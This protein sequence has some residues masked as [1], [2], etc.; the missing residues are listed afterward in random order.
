MTGLT[1]LVTGV[2]R[3]IGSA[4]AGY[5]AAHPS[6]DRVIGVDAAM[7]E[8]AARLRMGEAE[9]VRADIR[10]PL[11]SKVFEAAGVDTVV[12]ASASSTPSGSAA[13]TM[14]KEMNVLGTMQLLAACQRSMTLKNLIVRSTAAVYGGSSR[15]PA[16]ATEETMARAVPSTGLA[17]DAIDI[18]GYVRG[19]ARRR[20]DVR[21]A[22]PR[23]SEII[24][25]TVR[26]P[27]T[28][29][30]S[31][32][33]FVPISA[34][35]DARMQLVHEL[36]AVALIEHLVLGDF[37]GIVN[38]AG[39]GAMTVAQAIHRAGR[40]PLPIP[41]PALESVGRLLQAM[42]VGGFGG[43]SAAQIRL[44]SAGRVLDTSRLREQV[45]F[46]PRFSTTEAFDDFVGRLVPA[47]HPRA[48][49]AAELK[50]ASMIGVPAEPMGIRRARTAG[51]IADLAAGRLGAGTPDLPLGDVLVPGPGDVTDSTRPRLF[52]IDGDARR[53]LAVRSSRP[54]GRKK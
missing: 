2:T 11:I 49:R 42:G 41:S 48:V 52:S 16:V 45:G 22:V 5:L 8:P 25:P 13:R 34:G 9:F 44:L 29:Y 15:D 37:A 23:F 12:H 43:F 7:P 47:L 54:G 39:D 30:F 14:A 26:T 3:F 24:G 50:V 46:T 53:S 40:V 28:K 35:R 1:V 20:P 33:P 17:R 38:V 36:D 51:E 32:S 21:V 31:M 27:L 18:E 4:V 19:F 6:V 10:N